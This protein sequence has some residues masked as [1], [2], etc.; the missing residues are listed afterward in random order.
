MSPTSSRRYIAFKKTVEI[1]YR[2]SGGSDSLSNTFSTSVAGAALGRMGLVAERIS[3][4]MGMVDSATSCVFFPTART[5]DSRNCGFFATNFSLLRCRG[6][7]GFFRANSSFGMNT[8]LL[9]SLCDDW[10]A[11]RSAM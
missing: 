3:M 6:S 5:C 8:G 1:S 4:G 9:T 10:A 7:C 2:S 11:C